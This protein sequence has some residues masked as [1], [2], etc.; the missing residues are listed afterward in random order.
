MQDLSSSLNTN[1]SNFLAE[2]LHQFL[3][4]GKTNGGLC[5]R[6]DVRL[7]I[8]Y[9]E[10]RHLATVRKFYF[11]SHRAKHIIANDEGEYAIVYYRKERCFFLAAEKFC[12]YFQ[13]HLHL[14][15][16]S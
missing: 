6:R 8:S 9:L 11:V 2:I 5:S 12:G 7:F 13:A 15:L 10:T 1:Y 3:H 4:T 14:T 16:L